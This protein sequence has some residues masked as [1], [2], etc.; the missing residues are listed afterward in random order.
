LRGALLRGDDE[1][2]AT[3]WSLRELSVPDDYAAAVAVEG[4]GW[5]FRCWRWSE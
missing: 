3:H 2:G 1:G 4:D 5:R